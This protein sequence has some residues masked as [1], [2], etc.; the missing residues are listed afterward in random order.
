MNAGGLGGERREGV[1]LDWR[2][3][4][5]ETCWEQVIPQIALGDNGRCST[6]SRLK[7]SSYR[8]ADN[9][10]QDSRDTSGLGL[11]SPVVSLHTSS[12]SM[13]E[14]YS[15]QGCPHPRVCFPLKSLLFPRP[16]RIPEQGSLARQAHIL[17][18]C[19]THFSLKWSG[20]SYLSN[21]SWCS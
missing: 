1:W 4:S 16:T 10:S 21:T 11:Q 19:V 8:T 2:S 6:R 7:R 12:S 3:G 17:S 20:K 18:L 9:Y 14:I 13:Q 15:L 5:G